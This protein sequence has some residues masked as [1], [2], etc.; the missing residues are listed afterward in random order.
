M[1]LASYS[2]EDSTACYQLNRTVRSMLSIEVSTVRS[3]LSTEDSTV[4]SL[5]STEDSTVR[6]LLSTEVALYEVYYLLKIAH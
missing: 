4:R 5:L 1:Q 2:I 3:F 6:S